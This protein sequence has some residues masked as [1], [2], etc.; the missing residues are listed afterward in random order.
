MGAGAGLGGLHLKSKTKK[1][2]GSFSPATASP[3]F[4]TALLAADA[5]ILFIPPS[6]QLHRPVAIAPGVPEVPSLPT[7]PA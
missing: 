2:P 5:F 3:P 6:S 4:T 1:P 7:K